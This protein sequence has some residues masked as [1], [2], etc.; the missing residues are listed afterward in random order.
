MNS[1]SDR[2]QGYG[3]GNNSE[4]AARRCGYLVNYPPDEQW[5]Q[6]SM[7]HYGV[8]LLADAAVGNV[9]DH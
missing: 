1:V 7:Q 2:R 6:S 5:F 9:S 3:H 8:S 4:F